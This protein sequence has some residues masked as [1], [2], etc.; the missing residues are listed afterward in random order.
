MACGTCDQ[1][2]VMMIMY[3]SND[4]CVRKFGWELRIGR[5][6]A[7]R[8]AL[9]EYYTIGGSASRPVTSRVT[10]LVRL[11]VQIRGFGRECDRSTIEY[12]VSFDP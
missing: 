1:V 7:I 5:M 10:W 12:A 3:I 4:M 11:V 2:P 6:Q 8:V 9:S